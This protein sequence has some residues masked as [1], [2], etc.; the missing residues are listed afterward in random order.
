LRKNYSLVSKLSK[1]IALFSKALRFESTQ[2]TII[3]PSRIFIQ[4]VSTNWRTTMNIF[5]P[6]FIYKPGK[7]QIITGFLSQHPKLK[8]AGIDKLMVHT[9]LLNNWNNWAASVFD[10][11]LNY[12]FDAG[13]F[14]LNLPNITTAQQEDPVMTGYLPNSTERFELQNYSGLKL[15]DDGKLYCLPSLLS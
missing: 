10:S 7:E 3:S 8:E 14:P 6:D 5:Y 12:P 2:I 15:M 1:N 9:P 11:F 4:N 13:A